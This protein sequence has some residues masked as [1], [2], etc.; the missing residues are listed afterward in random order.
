MPWHE[1]YRRLALAFY[2]FY[3]KHGKDTGKALYKKCTQD[4]AFIAD[5]GWLVNYDNNYNVRSMDPIQIFASFTASKMKDVNRQ[6]R[7]NEFLVLMG[8]KPIKPLINYD[9]CPA[10]NPVQ[11]LNSRREIDHPKIWF[12]FKEALLKG[13]DGLTE[14]LFNGYQEWYGIQITSL[15]IFLFWVNSDSFLSLDGNT[16]SLLILAG[17]VTG[18]PGDLRGYNA[19]LAA[20]G[21]EVYRNLALLAVDQ[22]YAAHLDDQQKRDLIEYLGEKGEDLLFPSQTEGKKANEDDNAPQNEKSPQDQRSDDPEKGKQ[23]EELADALRQ[24]RFQ[25]LAIR[26]LEMKDELLK[27]LSPGEFYHFYKQYTFSEE[28]G[29]IHLAYHPE[30]DLTIYDAETEDKAGQP[31]ISISA[32]VGKNGAGK[33][34][35]VELLIMAINNIAGQYFRH[36]HPNGTHNVDPVPGLKMELYFKLGPTTIY[37]VRIDGEDVDVFLLRLSDQFEGEVNSYWGVDVPPAVLFYS[38][39]ANYSLHGL[40]SNDREKPWLS[41]L[42]H[43]NDAYQVP[44]VLTPWRDNGTINVSRLFGQVK[45]RLVVNLLEYLGLDLAENDESKEKKLSESFRQLT[46]TQRAEQLRFQLKEKEDAIPKHYVDEDQKLNFPFEEVTP[47]PAQVFEEFQVAFV[48]TLPLLNSNLGAIIPAYLQKKLVTMCLRYPQYGIFFDRKT[49][50]FKNLPVLFEK[51]EKDPSHIAYK[52][53]RVINFLHF[54]LYPGEN[55]LICNIE[56]LSIRINKVRQENPNLS[57]ETLIPPSF[58]TPVVELHTQ[59][60]PETAP[61]ISFQRLSSGEKQ[62]IYAVSSLIYHLRNLNSVNPSKNI[63]KYSSVNVVFDEVELYFHPEW[64]RTYIDYML[65]MIRRVDLPEISSINICFV[66]HSPFILSDIPSS[67]VLFLKKENTAKGKTRAVRAPVP[68]FAANIHE[69]LIDGFFM[70]NSVGEFARKKIE[71]I[72]EFSAEFGQTPKDTQNQNL[73][74][75]VGRGLR[76]HKKVV[77]TIGEDY[78]R[79]IL[80]NH[81]EEVEKNWF[82]SSFRQSKIDRLREELEREEKLQATENKQGDNQP[83]SF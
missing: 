24:T 22:L 79:G 39:L 41:K 73:R 30:A 61:L 23:R 14:D 42:F 6:K 51:I 77:R 83:N 50:Q 7:L 59:G 31:K 18:R 69:L 15:T 60:A 49:L 54:Q 19:L 62:R 5:K 17:K 53:K 44:I 40:R 9:G 56:E 64:Q 70:E 27:T 29:K 63:H 67:N 21:T 74:T 81:L 38:T 28:K 55:E 25:L 1:A 10:P 37:Q 71:N 75:T 57:I 45:S 11:L 72:L 2:E 8:Q 20:E 26:P 78:I 3:I 76:E 68:T 65:R 34:N 13:Q 58:Y 82:P 32:I 16:L 47:D 36:K 33:S 4:K 46:D 35:L 48:D 12:L 52:F 43:K 80:E 66:T